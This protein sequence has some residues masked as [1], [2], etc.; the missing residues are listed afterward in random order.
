RKAR[1]AAGWVAGPAGNG[2]AR[3]GAR[4]EARRRARW[5][6]YRICRTR[7]LYPYTK[8]DVLRSSRIRNVGARQ[9]QDHVVGHAGW[10]PDSDRA[11]PWQGHRL[12]DA[13]GC[14]VR[15]EL[16]RQC[17]GATEEVP[18]GRIRHARSIRAFTFLVGATNV[19]KL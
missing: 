5:R 3:R 7:W 4:R 11:A 1:R 19:P 2:R 10:N 6:I 15:L 9:T 8:E 12:V 17:V 13:S 14:L 18:R 16:D